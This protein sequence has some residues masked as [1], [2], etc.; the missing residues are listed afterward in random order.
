[1]LTDG[2][3]NI[4]RD[5]AKQWIIGT[6][7]NVEKL[8]VVGG[9]LEREAVYPSIKECLEKNTHLSQNGLPL[10]EKVM[11]RFYLYFHL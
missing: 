6:N 7:A 10:G 5:R 8:K 3:K 1:M 11:P 4:A 9:S 2:S